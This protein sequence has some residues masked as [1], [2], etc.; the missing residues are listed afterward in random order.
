MQESEDSASGAQKSALIT[1]ESIDAL[2]LHTASSNEA[3][4][5]HL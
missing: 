4:Y 2:Q 1:G 5:S 3:V